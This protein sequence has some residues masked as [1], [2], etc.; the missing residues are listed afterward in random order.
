MAKGSSIN[1]LGGNGGVNDSY[2]VN[3][4]GKVSRPKMVVET[5]KNLHPDTHISRRN[6][7]KFL[8][9]NPNNDKPDNINE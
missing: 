5:E 1:G 3:G 4:R 9:N 7:K 6:G 8:R 2:M